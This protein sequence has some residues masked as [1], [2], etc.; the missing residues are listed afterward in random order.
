MDPVGDN[1]QQE[2]KYQR[3][4]MSGKSLDWASQPKIYKDYPD[5][6]TISLPDITPL[7]DTTLHDVLNNRKSIMQYQ[8]KP[9]KVR[10][11]S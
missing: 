5:C 9:I 11:D 7:S 8:N 3:G 1:F 2:T 10:S 4:K 6:R